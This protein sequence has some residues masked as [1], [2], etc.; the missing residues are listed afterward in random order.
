MPRVAETLQAVFLAPS[1]AEGKQGWK[2]RQG[3]LRPTMGVND[4]E[5]FSPCQSA[6][7]AGSCRPAESDLLCDSRGR[8]DHSTP[9]FIE[10]EQGRWCSPSEPA[11]SF[12]IPGELPGEGLRSFSGLIG[13][14][15]HTD[16]EETQPGGHTSAGHGVSS[17]RT[18]SSSVSFGHT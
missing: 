18:S 6:Y 2:D 7:R 8:D 14:C 11:H 15:P 1:D 3:R 17:P 12:A 5:I 16:E 9:Q 4:I 13:Y 10:D